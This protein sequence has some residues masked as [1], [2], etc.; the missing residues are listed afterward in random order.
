MLNTILIFQLA[1]IKIVSIFYKVQHFTFSSI[2]VFEIAIKIKK[3][4]SQKIFLIK[5]SV[6]VLKSKLVL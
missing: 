3:S 1:G 6:N 4:E 2:N 5:F